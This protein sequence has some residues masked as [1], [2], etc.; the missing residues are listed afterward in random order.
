MSRELK[1]KQEI[2]IGDYVYIVRKKKRPYDLQKIDCDLC[3]STGYVYDNSKNRF[4]CPKC[5]GLGGSMISDKYEQYYEVDA[6]PYLVV[7]ARLVSADYPFVVYNIK[8]MKRLIE[9]SHEF[10]E[11]DLFKTIEEAE[12]YCKNN[13]PK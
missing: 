11:K 7:K 6:E 1:K 5:K 8:D 12:E 9:V 13:V 2:L 4:E 3:D 10:I